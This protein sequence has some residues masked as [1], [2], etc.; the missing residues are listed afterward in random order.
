MLDAQAVF[1]RDVA[2][3]GVQPATRRSLEVSHLL[4]RVG[5]LNFWVITKYSE[6][7]ALGVKSVPLQ[8]LCEVGSI[9]VTESLLHFSQVQSQLGRRLWSTAT[10][11][12]SVCLPDRLSQGGRREPR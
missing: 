4:N 2:G 6:P 8:R 9:V 10:S 12:R 7:D 1:R 5:H 3:L 11:F